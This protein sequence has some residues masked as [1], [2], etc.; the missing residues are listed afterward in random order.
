M[1]RKLLKHEFRA[2]GRVMLPMYLI[3]LIIALC[4]NFAVR[5]IDGGG[6]N[7]L[8]I[9]SVIILVAFFVMI[10]GLI[11]MSLCM[12]VQRFAKNL[13]GDEGYIMFTLP[14]SVHRHIFSKII[15]SV[16]WFVATTL[17]IALACLFIS[18]RA[19]FIQS[20]IDFVIALFE[21]ITRY[22]ALKGGAMIVEITAAV[23]VSLAAFCLQVYAAISI[24]YGFSNH[25][26]L[27]SIAS[28]VV[29]QIVMWMLMSGIIQIIGI[30]ALNR[31]ISAGFNIMTGFHIT[32]WSNIAFQLLHGA[33]YYAITAV[34]LKKRLNLE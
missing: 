17:I 6:N 12:M 26:V 2:T 18:F 19:D 25:K 23:I 22:Y 9:F 1:L 31:W 7:Y 21:G 24:G 20:I 30:T 10:I 3:M 33:V 5:V 14:V 8:R 32:M 13:M 28:I 4:G 34:S 16:V 27:L 29:M 11:I 15:V